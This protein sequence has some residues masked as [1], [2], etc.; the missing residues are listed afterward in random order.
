MPSDMLKLPCTSFTNSSTL[1][2]DDAGEYVLASKITKQLR[3]IQ[4]YYQICKSKAVNAAFTD[5]GSEGPERIVG[6]IIIGC[7][8]ACQYSCKKIVMLTLK[9][10]Q[11]V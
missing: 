4:G 11:L 9:I 5:H 7:S 8:A 10:L 1:N 6:I 2:Q 3:M